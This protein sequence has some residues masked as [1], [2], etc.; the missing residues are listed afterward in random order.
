MLP[1]WFRMVR[2]GDV[3]TVSNSKD[4]V[5][6]A[7]PTGATAQTIPMGTSVLAGLGVSAATDGLIATATFD[8]VTLNGTPVPGTGLRGRTVGFVNEQGSESYAGGVWTLN[9]SGTSLNA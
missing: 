3:F 7:I 1:Q 8:N 5:T 2:A 4:G 9:G 6:W